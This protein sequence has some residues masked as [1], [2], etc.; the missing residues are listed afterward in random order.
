MCDF[1][2]S[3]LRGGSVLISRLLEGFPRDRV[4]VLTGS[5]FNSSSPQQGRLSCKQR[6]FPTSN[7]T[8]R[9]G[10]G[11]IKTMFDWIAL[12]VLAL[13]GARVVKTNRIKAIV[14]IAHGHFFVAATLVG[15]ITGTPVVLV[16]HDDWVA[17]VRR[18]SFVLKH[19][20]A[21][22]FQFA[23]RRAAHIY[24]VTPYMKEMIERKYGV[25]AEVQ[26]PA[27]DPTLDP[28]IAAGLTTLGAAAQAG[29]LRI[30]YAGTLTGATDDSFALLVKLVKGDKLL[31]YGI[32]SWELL[33]F[34]MATE[35]QIKAAGW[36][37]ERINVQG[38]VSQDELAA[39]LTT[40]DILFLPFSFREEERFATSQAFPTK[41]ADYLKSGKPVLIFAP[42]YSS[43][44]KYSQQFG[45]AE[46]VDECSEEKLAEAIARIWGSASY[47]RE[48]AENSQA[49]L[50]ANHDINQ[51]RA[52][53][54]RLLNQ[55]AHENAEAT[56][57]SRT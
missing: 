52:S 39:A 2:P 22:V 12:P 4:V 25:K 32:T 47:R 43:L 3:N 45:F 29:C 41:T 53:F 54:K 46:I 28:N 18:E 51:Q 15:W 17:G 11:R 24:A 30:V 38:W 14:T 57:S 16:V 23:A 48:L 37:H 31:N 50:M 55:L 13:Y 7:G 27:I 35:E 21:R 1:P 10:L 9:W 6:V 34:I 8:G 36:Q 5:Y 40:A 19:F 42:P 20:S 44:V 56:I 26:M 49:A 33:L